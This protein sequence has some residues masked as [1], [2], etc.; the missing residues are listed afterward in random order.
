MLRVKLKS[1]EINFAPYQH[2]R[3]EILN[4]SKGTHSMSTMTP[5]ILGLAGFQ[6]LPCGIFDGVAMGQVFLQVL[7]AVP[8]H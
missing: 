8:C 5:A 3:Y 4:L 6:A 7:T 1:V 2:D